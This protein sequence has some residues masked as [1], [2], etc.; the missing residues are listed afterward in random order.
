MNN[1]GFSLVETL[2]ALSL[3]A[4]VFVG[5]LSVLAQNN[6]EVARLNE[7][8]TRERNLRNAQ[9]LLRAGLTKEFVEDEL[10]LLSIT[11]VGSNLP[12]DSDGSHIFTLNGRNYLV[13]QRG[14]ENG[15]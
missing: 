7:A 9:S 14:G 3:T 13:S 8:N 4:S 15:E 12:S 11:E 6:R 10:Y 2:V 5:F 1:K